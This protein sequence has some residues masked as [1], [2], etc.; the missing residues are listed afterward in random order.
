ML[1][2]RCYEV[3][4][5][6]VCVL[7]TQTPIQLTNEWFSL[8]FRTFLAFSSAQNNASN[9]AHEI[10]SIIIIL[11]RDLYNNIIATYIQR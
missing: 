4:M 1:T 7:I 2:G 6:T 8:R 10:Q 9:S 3:E 5:C 11:Y